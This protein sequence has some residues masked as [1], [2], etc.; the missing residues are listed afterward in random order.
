MFGGLLTML[1]EPIRGALQIREHWHRF[2][3]VEKGI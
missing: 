3:D 2:C 1:K